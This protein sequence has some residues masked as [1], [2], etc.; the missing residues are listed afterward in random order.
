MKTKLEDLEDLAAVVLCPTE[1]FRRALLAA[2]PSLAAD[3]EEAF[4]LPDSQTVVLL[5]GPEDDD[6][7][8]EFLVPHKK[9]LAEK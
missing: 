8:E 7:L 3:L 5:P 6:E 2:D 1:S 9:A 4:A